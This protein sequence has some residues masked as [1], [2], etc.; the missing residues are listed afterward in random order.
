MESIVPVSVE[1]KIFTIMHYYGWG[2]PSKVSFSNISQMFWPIGQIDQVE[3]FGIFKITFKKHT[4]CHCA[5]L[6]VRMNLLSHHFSQNTNVKLSGFLPFIV[7]AEILTIFCLYFGRNNDLISSFWNWLTFS[8]SFC[9][10]TFAL[11]RHLS[12]YLEFWHHT[13]EVHV[14]NL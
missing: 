12:V 6:K 10:L 9:T 13:S 8:P 14:H 3:L 5:P 2:T 4:F 11:I 1:E 7:K